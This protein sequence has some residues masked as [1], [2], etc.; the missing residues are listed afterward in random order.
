LWLQRWDAANIGA[1]L[2]KLKH[3]HQ[4]A[5]QDIVNVI[6]LVTPFFYEFVLE[7]YRRGSKEVVNLSWRQ[8][9]SRTYQLLFHRRYYCR[10]QNRGGIDI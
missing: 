8:K 6:Q 9:G 4:P 2:L 7:P 10:Q 3:E 1:F 5:Y